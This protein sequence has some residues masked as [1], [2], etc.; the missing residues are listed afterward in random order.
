MSRR[1]MF[2]PLLAVL[3]VGAVAAGC[4]DDDEGGAQ[5]TAAA[6]ETTSM[7]SETT[8][9]TETTA[10][11]ETTVAPETTL[12]LLPDN[13][14]CDDSLAPVV[15]SIETT[16]ESSVL[17]LI[18]QVKAA[19]A[20]VEA[21]NGRG[22]V[23]GRCMEL[24]SCDDQADPNIAADCARSIVESDAVASVNDTTT[25]GDAAVAEIFTAA[26]Y[27]RVGQ[28]AGTPDLSA[29]NSYN[30][31]G[32]SL[33]TV[34]QMIPP[35]LE[36]GK[37]K[38]AAIHVDA[39]AF[40]GAIGLIEAIAG[41]GGAELVATIPVPAG[42]TNYDQFVLAAEDAGADG[43]IMALGDK[44]SVQVLTAAGQLGTELLFSASL[45][46]WSRAAMLDLGEMGSQMVFNAE[47]PPA[48]APV[49]QFPAMAQ[50]IADLSASGEPELQA[51]TLQSSSLR[52]WLAVYAFVTVMSATDVDNITRESVT[53]A[54]N[55]ATDIDMLGIMNPWTPNQVSPGAFSRISNPWYYFAT[56][57]GENFVTTDTPTGNI[58]ETLAPTGLVG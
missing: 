58:L 57:D 32:G 54:F 30:I 13:G 5:T 51:D 47:V 22:G 2:M 19:E 23:G 29:P 17:T 37:T 28:S 15:L 3:A 55:A 49:E 27:P 8:G 34:F 45:G 14:E 25:F 42:T 18:H 1:S 20:A 6:S 4:G 24:M 35:L 10:A 26:N 52:S 7:A 43:V 21:F 46:T 39:A 12:G 36:A 9:A 38:L 31:G 11:P 40:Q 16:F 44:E 56:W 33:G 48:S 53:A 50:I 41:A